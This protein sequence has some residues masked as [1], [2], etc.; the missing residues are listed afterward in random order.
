MTTRQQ[1]ERAAE[2]VKEA[3]ERDDSARDAFLDEACAG[4]GELR[5]EVNPSCGFAPDARDFIEEG[6]LQ[7]AAQTLP[8]P[9]TQ[10]PVRHIEGYEIISHIGSGGMG[11]VYLARDT[12]LQRNVALK[13]VRMDF[14]APGIVA[15]FGH[16]E[17]ILASLNHPN[18][19]QLYD[20]GIATGEIPFFAMEYI[21]GV[22]LDEDCNA[23]ALSVRERL[24]LF[25]KVCAAVHYAHQRLVIHRDLKPSNILVTPDGEPKLLDFG[26]AKIVDPEGADSAQT[27]TLKNVMTPDYASPEQVRGESMTTASDIYSLGVILYELLTGERPVPPNDAPPE[28]S[29]QGHHRTGAAAAEHRGAEQ[30]AKLRVPRSQISPRRPRHHRADGA[31]E[32]A[33][34]PLRLGGA[35][36]GGHRTPPPGPAGSG[37]QGHACLSRDEVHQ[38]EQDR[39]LGGAACVAHAGGRHHRHHE[40]GAHRGGAT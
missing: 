32:R 12:K 27:I 35:I 20:A 33:G 38:A 22:R 1:T 37:S 16:E 13:L 40:A 2:L 36:L 34:A 29:R 8:K 30:R 19:A 17:R 23:K 14:G 25:R 18:I 9:A 28:R 26:I 3:L 24:E 10:P 7:L 6:A 4:D 39:S 15:R 31:A 11:E 21:E 5:E